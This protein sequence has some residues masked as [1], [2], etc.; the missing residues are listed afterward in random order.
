MQ[1][2]CASTLFLGSHG[3]SGSNVQLRHPP[4]IA[5]HHIHEYQFD[6]QW[7][8]VPSRRFYVRDG[9]CKK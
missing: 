9:S 8:C 1:I 6:I 7:I 3:G 2:L 4:H 5:T